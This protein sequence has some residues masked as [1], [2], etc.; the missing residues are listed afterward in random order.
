MLSS[1]SLTGLVL[2]VSP[3]NVGQL[4]Y[5]DGWEGRWWACMSAAVMYPVPDIGLED[6]GGRGWACKP[7]AGVVCV[8]V[9]DLSGLV[10]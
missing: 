5:L 2:C 1:Q 3:E 6:E 10:R 4:S 9:P 7:L 8:P